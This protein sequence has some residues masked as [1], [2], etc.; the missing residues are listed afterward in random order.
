MSIADGNE[1][2]SDDELLYRR[3]P[4]SQGWYQP[5]SDTLSPQAFHPREDDVTGLSLS[6]VRFFVTPADAARGASKRGYWLAVLRA[7]DLRARG[8]HVVPSPRDGDPGHAEIEDLRY[9]NRKSDEAEGWKVAMA[10]KLWI[11]V[12]GPF[13]PT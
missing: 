1:P 5:E 8:M 9:D 4:V 7:A 13:L 12:L 2:V 6:R 3:I 10:N 11:E